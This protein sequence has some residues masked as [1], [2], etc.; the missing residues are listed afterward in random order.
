MGSIDLWRGQPTPQRRVAVPSEQL[1]NDETN[2]MLLTPRQ[3][4]NFGQTLRFI[5]QPPALLNG[6]QFAPLLDYFENGEFRRAAEVDGEAVLY[7]V[8]E[9]AQNPLQLRVRILAG[10]SHAHTTKAVV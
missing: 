5:L 9:V 8:R 10:P 7:G 1:R 6:R 3:P 4:F 2:E